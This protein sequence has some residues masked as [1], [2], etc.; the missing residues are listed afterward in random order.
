MTIEIKVSTQADVDE[1]DA[2]TL[3]DAADVL[4]RQL[5]DAVD[6]LAVL[7]MTADMLDPIPEDD[8]IVD[9]EAATYAEALEAAAKALEEAVEYQWNGNPRR[10]NNYRSAATFV[11]SLPNPY[12]K[13]DQ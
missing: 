3:R 6:A 9:Y 7:D 13:A 4:R 5:P 8:L 2:A 12:G 1:E 10:P 11:R